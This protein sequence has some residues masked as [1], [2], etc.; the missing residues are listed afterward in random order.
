MR[1]NNNSTVS[2]AKTSVYV[3]QSR[4]D[5]VSPT[6]TMC[7]MQDGA[8]VA[9]KPSD[10]GN[11]FF[12]GISQGSS[13]ISRMVGADY[14]EMVELLTRAV[15]NRTRQRNY[16]RLQNN[17]LE[18]IISEDDFYKEIEEKEDEYVVEEMESPSPERLRHAMILSQGIKDVQNSEDLSTLF[19]F[20]SEATDFELKKI[21]SDGSLQQC[22]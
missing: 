18:G 2:I 6:V 7:Q 16:F 22:R 11:V 12:A 4:S 14:A 21:E 1:K 13:V 3:E 15:N 19:S 5:E 17:L 10:N 8:F 9:V 20:S